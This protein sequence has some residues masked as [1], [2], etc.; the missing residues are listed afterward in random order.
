MRRWLLLLFLA[1]APWPEMLYAGYM[2]SALSGALPQ[3][4]KEFRSNPHLLFLPEG[5]WS[6]EF[7]RLSRRALWEALLR[8]RKAPPQRRMLVAVGPSRILVW[9]SDGKKVFGPRAHLLRRSSAGARY[10]ERRQMR[11]AIRYFQKRRGRA[12]RSP[13]DL[14][15]L[16]RAN[17]AVPRDLLRQRFEEVRP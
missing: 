17:P 6:L 1:S 12:P 10:F 2:A 9:V 14:L 3:N 5:A 15:T 7:Q 11:V 16:L 8:L 13:E 4:W